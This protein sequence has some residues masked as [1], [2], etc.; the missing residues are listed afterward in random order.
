GDDEGSGGGIGRRGDMRRHDDP[1]VPPERVRH[2]QRLGP[3]DV[4]DGGGELT[5]V[6]R[7]NEILLDE[8]SAAPG[9]HDRRA[10]RQPGEQ[11]GG[12][13][14]LRLGRERQEADENVRPRKERIEPLGAVKGNDPGQALLGAAPD[15]KSTRLN[16][17]H[18]KIS[19]AVFCLKKKT[20]SA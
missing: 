12:E 7:G 17:S 20:P 1:L 10:P 3:E 4:E 15:R 5:G 19:Y 14:A 8:V 6:E 9:V 2:R 13:D 16:S 11:R 18:V